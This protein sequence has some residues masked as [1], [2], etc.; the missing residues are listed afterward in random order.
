MPKLAPITPK[1]VAA[2]A[3]NCGVIS[4][5]ASAV[6]FATLIIPIWVRILAPAIPPTP[7]ASNKPTPIPTIAP[8]SA[9][10]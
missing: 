1:T 2:A 6:S 7:L 9:T 8:T 3:N 4:S 10:L 5:V